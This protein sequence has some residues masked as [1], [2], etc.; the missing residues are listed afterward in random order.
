VAP[1]RPFDRHC[2]FDVPGKAARAICLFLEA[3]GKV[4]HKRVAQ[5]TTRFVAL[6]TVINTAG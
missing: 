1:G 3:V 2:L 4:L 5:M 6:P